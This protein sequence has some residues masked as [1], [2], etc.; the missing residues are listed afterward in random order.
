[1][2][3]ETIDIHP[4]IC[5]FPVYPRDIITLAGIILIILSTM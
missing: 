5:C 4:K 1:M 2:V 3:I